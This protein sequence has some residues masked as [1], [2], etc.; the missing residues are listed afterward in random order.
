LAIFTD[1]VAEMSTVI[2]MRTDG[3]VQTSSYTCFVL[4]CGVQLME[5]HPLSEFIED[6]CISAY[7]VAGHGLVAVMELGEVTVHSFDQFSQ[8]M[9]SAFGVTVTPAKSSE[10]QIFAYM[11]DQLAFIPISTEDSLLTRRDTYT[12]LAVNKIDTIVARENIILKQLLALKQFAEI[13]PTHRVKRSLASWIL[14][15]DI[16][17]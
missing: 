13:D 9:K 6:T 1:S 12:D 7:I 2:T 17:I 15:P 4:E 16:G 14:S 10:H 8:N 11:N 3:Y 5:F